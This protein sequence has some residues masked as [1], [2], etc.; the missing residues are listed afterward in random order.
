[1]PIMSCSTTWGMLRY[2]TKTFLRVVVVMWI[3]CIKIC[4]E[5]SVVSFQ[6]TTESFC[7]FCHNWGEHT[8]EDILF[9]AV[10]LL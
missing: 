2:N 1:M 6:H 3:K 4:N 7:L 5:L 8:E 9:V 10:N